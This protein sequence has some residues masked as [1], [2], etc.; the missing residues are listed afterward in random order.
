MS[1]YYDFTAFMNNQKHSINTI[2]KDI[3]T[4]RTI[5]EEATQA[6]LNK[7]MTYKK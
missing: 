6:G 3:K 5:L 2:G 4:L 1:F 7:N